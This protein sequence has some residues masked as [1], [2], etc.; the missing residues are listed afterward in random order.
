MDITKNEGQ[1]GEWHLDWGHEDGST[2]RMATKYRAGRGFEI[3]SQL[4]WYEDFEGE[5]VPKEDRWLS[6]RIGSFG[7]IET[8]PL[9]VLVWLMTGQTRASR[10]SRKAS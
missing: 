10:A 1:I 7:G 8:L 3:E 2:N 4:I 5:P 6:V 9:D